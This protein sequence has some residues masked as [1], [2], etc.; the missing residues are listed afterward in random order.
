MAVVSQRLPS[1]RVC[2]CFECHSWL[3][4]ELTEAHAWTRAK[5]TD[6]CV[7][8]VEIF[9]QRCDAH[10]VTFRDRMRTFG[11]RHFSLTDEGRQNTI[12]RTV[13][14]HITMEELEVARRSSGAGIYSGATTQVCD[15]NTH[16]ATY[17]FD[18]DRP[19]D[20]MSKMAIDHLFGYLT[21]AICAGP[22][23]HRHCFCWQKREPGMVQCYPIKRRV[24]EQVV[25]DERPAAPVET[26]APTWNSVAAGVSEPIGETLDVPHVLN[27]AVPGVEL[28][29]DE[30][31]Q[32]SA[33]AL[34]ARYLPLIEERIF[35]M[36]SLQ[37][38]QDAIKG[39]IVLPEVP[40]TLTALQT[41]EL[42]EV[43][44][45]MR[46]V[47]ARDIKQGILAKIVQSTLGLTAWGSRKWTPERVTRA[48]KEAIER[49][50]P[51]YV[52]SG[53]VKLE[54]GKRGK[55][56]RLI[57]SDGDQGQLL[58]MVIIGVLEKW[59]FTRYKERS[60]KGLPKDKAMERVAKCL[61]IHG[62]PEA[63]QTSGTLPEMPASILEND[64][65]AWDAC[66]SLM[67]REI[68]E[69]GIMDDV[70]AEVQKFCLI[71][72]TPQFIAARVASNKLKKL[73]I[74]FRKPGPN[75]TVGDE[76]MSAFSDLPKSKCWKEF[77]RSIRRSGCRGTSC[78]NFISN[79]VL[80]A[81][82]I[83]GAAGARLM[84]P[85]G[86]KVKC[87]DGLVRFIKFAFEGDDSIVSCYCPLHPDSS[88]TEGLRKTMEERWTAAG[89]RPKLAWRKPGEVAE[90]TGWLFQVQPSGI[91]YDQCSPDLLRQLV[92]LAYTTNKAAV[93]AAADG[94]LAEFMAHVAP[95]VLARIYPLARR[96]PRLA[97]HLYGVIAP[98]LRLDTQF[99]WDD[100]HRLGIEP[101]DVGFKEYTFHQQAQDVEADT[102]C[103]R[104]E[105]GL[106]KA[107]CFLQRFQL[108]LAQADYSGEA[109]LAVHIG[110]CKTSA[111]YEEF[112]DLYKAAA[113][114]GSGADLRRQTLECRQK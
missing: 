81:W 34:A 98:Y 77:I 13:S 2:P 113:Y 32:P 111:G 65:S 42:K 89:H 55:P 91:N 101:E 54:P 23:Q 69:N 36:N 50:D 30:K 60:I 33:G 41:D 74:G 24:V 5:D 37:R 51:R 94:K 49:F 62:Q 61:K 8:C 106:E 56:P 31:A 17:R 38:A 16:F 102:P 45:A 4:R 99:T 85:N 71:E 48:F 53:S 103:D 46:D 18:A 82:V 9:V 44:R 14:V 40:V 12:H 66:M 58:A 15:S 63:D 107:R 21:S 87:V 67:L 3:L 43:A 105:R 93:K 25:D 112:L 27:S 95:G 96:F 72:G 39:R 52:F 29:F 11:R 108:E 90:F 83:A 80:W 114:I 1:R 73:A 7:F 78:L 20:A 110:F 75:A 26:P 68:T 6:P 79:M 19:G 109:L 35:F 86:Q 76:D 22:V 10:D 59:L 57:I 64:G 28:V 92:S 100:I 47:L 104:I 70:A 88:M 84:E 97:S